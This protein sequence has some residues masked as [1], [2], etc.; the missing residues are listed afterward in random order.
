MLPDQPASGE[1]G[2]KYKQTGHE[3]DGQR[4]VEKMTI[5]GRKSLAINTLTGLKTTENA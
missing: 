5:G 3:K 2:R 4:W 1:H